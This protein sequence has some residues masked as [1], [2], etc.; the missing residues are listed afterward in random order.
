MP[1]RIG[2]HLRR[3]RHKA[4]SALHISRSSN[5]DVQE[6][7]RRVEKVLPKPVENKWKISLGGSFR[8]YNSFTGV[9][10]N[11]PDPG[12]IRYEPSIGPQ[13]TCMQMPALPDIIENC[14]WCVGIPDHADQCSGTCRS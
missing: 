1:P 4:P 14:R 11:T 7:A 3:E 13:K 8:R 10:Q 12:P 5:E 2:R 6:I 9:S